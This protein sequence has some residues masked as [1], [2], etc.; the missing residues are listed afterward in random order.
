VSCLA[1]I[2]PK[3]PEDYFEVETSAESDLFITSSR[4]DAKTFNESSSSALFT[5]IVQI[6]W[7]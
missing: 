3:C 5:Y 1:G 7:P 6:S 4:G 2:E